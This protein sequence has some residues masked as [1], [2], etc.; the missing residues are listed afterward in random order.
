MPMMLTVPHSFREKMTALYGVQGEVWVATVPALVARCAER[1]SLT[2][3]SPYESPSYNLV[4]CV[5][6]ADGAPLALKLGVPVP[7]LLCEIEALRLYDGEGCVRLIAASPED[8]AL[9]LERLVPGAMLVSLADDDQATRI[10][11]IVMQQLWRPLPE[12]HPFPTT[13]KWAEGMKRL[14]TTFGG[15]CGPF[16][17]RL[18]QAAETLFTDLLTTSQESVLL[19]GDLHHYNILAAERAPWLAIDPKGLSGERLYET[20]ALLRNPLPEVSSWADLRRVLARRA[21]ILAEALEADRQR[22]LGWGM[23][24]AVLSSWWSYEDEGERAEETLVMA[25]VLLDLYERT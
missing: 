10:A 15:G 5:S 6:G 2:V 1:W 9:L 14:R 17:E 21:S 8:G 12:A 11:A 23:A 25:G 16:P 18:V 3:G 13:A 22:I 4:I 7:E 24:Q 19:H 20:G